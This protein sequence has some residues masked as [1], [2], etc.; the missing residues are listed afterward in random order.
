MFNPFT[1]PACQISGLKDARMRMQTVY[2]QSCNSSTSNV[3]NFDENG[4][5]CQS[6]KEDKMT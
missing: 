6:E 4:F 5:T 2:F 1:A 3:L